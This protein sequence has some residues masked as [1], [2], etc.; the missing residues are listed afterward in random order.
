MIVVGLVV[1]DEEQMDLYQLRDS[2]GFSE[3][4][5]NQI[6]D[7]EKVRSVLKDQDAVATVYLAEDKR[8]A[9][10]QQEDTP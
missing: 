8:L 5:D 7:T 9:P 6:L 4:A 2:L 3:H 1:V 10:R